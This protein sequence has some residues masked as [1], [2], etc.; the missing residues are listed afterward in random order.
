LDGDLERLDALVAVPR[1][2]QLLLE[3]VDVLDVLLLRH[4]Q[5]GLHGALLVV[6]QGLEALLRLVHHGC[7]A[8]YAT[9]ERA[10]WVSA[11]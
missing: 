3:L 1:G 6:L 11:R 10:P 2:D 9:H 4:V 5:H 7:S 8:R